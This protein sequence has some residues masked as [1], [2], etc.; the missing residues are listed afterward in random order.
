[1][2]KIRWKWLITVQYNRRGN[3]IWF[4]GPLFY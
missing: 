4:G 1:M 3:N 2:R